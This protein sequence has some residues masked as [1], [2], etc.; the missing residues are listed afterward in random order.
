MDS[1]PFDILKK[2]FKS[3][4]ELG[5]NRCANVSSM[6]HNAFGSN[7]QF[8]WRTK[9]R[10]FLAISKLLPLC[11]FRPTNL[12][13]KNCVPNTSKVHCGI[14]RNMQMSISST[15]LSRM[16]YSKSCRQPW[17]FWSNVARI[18]QNS[19]STLQFRK[20]ATWII[21]DV[22]R[23]KS[24]TFHFVWY[25]W[26]VDS[27]PEAR[28][29]RS[30]SNNRNELDQFDR[31]PAAADLPHFWPKLEIASIDIH[32]DVS[33]EQAIKC[34]VNMPNVTKLNLLESSWSS[35]QPGKSVERLK[36]VVSGLQC[37]ESFTMRHRFFC[38]A[39]QFLCWSCWTL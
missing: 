21:L 17:P 11:Q 9:T 23:P 8:V 10:P 22:S 39:C 25:R 12:C 14:W 35:E 37:L 13:F 5:A 16:A 15:W 18:W 36:S 34:V 32:Q 20:T 3:N 38:I 31:I 7:S 2:I 26:A 33:V 4:K 29:C 1:L 6:W 24:E 27:E 19:L 28:F 30:G